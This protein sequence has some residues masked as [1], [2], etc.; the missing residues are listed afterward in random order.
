[1]LCLQLITNPCSSHAQSTQRALTAI[2]QTKQKSQ[3]VKRKEKQQLCLSPENL[4]QPVL[5]AKSET[6]SAPTTKPGKPQ[7]ITN[8]SPLP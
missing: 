4:S 7:I 3:E 6:I 2:T 8:S 1:M 5:K